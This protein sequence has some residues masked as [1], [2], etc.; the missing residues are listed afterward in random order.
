MWNTTCAEDSINL[1]SVRN[2]YIMNTGI[3]IRS[4]YRKQLPSIFSIFFRYLYILISSSNVFLTYLLKYFKI[5]FLSLIVSVATSF[6]PQRGY[7]SPTSVVIIYLLSLCFWHFDLHS[8]S[9][10]FIFSS[11]WDLCKW[12]QNIVCFCI[13]N[14]FLLSLLSH[15]YNIHQHCQYG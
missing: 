2:S 14:S 6:P 8:K 15:V 5:S 1:H 12:N 3:I 11:F 13:K 7:H 9:V 10:W 4:E